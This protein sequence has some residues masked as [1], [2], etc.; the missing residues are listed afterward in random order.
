MSQRIPRV[1]IDGRDVDF[2]RA[3]YTQPGGL[4]AASLEFNLPIQEEIRKLWNKEV[5]FYVDKGDSKPIFRGWINRT[6]KTDNDVTIFAEDAIGYMIKGGDTNVAKIVFDETQNVDGLTV[7]AAIKKIIELAKLDSKI[8]TDY[9]GDTSPRIGSVQKTPIRGTLDILSAIKTLLARPINLADQ[10]LPRQN[11]LRVSDDGEQSQLFIELQADPATDP[12]KH[13]YTNDHNIISLDVIDR[14]VPT[15]IVVNG[16]D[17]TTGTFTHDGAIEALDRSYLE[18]TNENLESPAECKTFAARLYQ[19]NLKDRYQYGIRVTDGYYLNENDVVRVETRD[20]V[21]SG[22]YRVVAKRINA[23]QGGYEI[24][25]TINKKAPTLAE[26]IGS[27]D[28]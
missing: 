25:I 13:I 22:N 21:Y 7:G 10:S 1:T 19:A 27:R 18:V 26:Y 6:K 23:N 20:N 4:A 5:T 11:I 2:V 9:I 17:G 28:N 8:G 12:I 16:K 14:K 24:G 3:A 15:Y